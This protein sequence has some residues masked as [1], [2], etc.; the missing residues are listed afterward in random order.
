[1]LGAIPPGIKSGRPRKWSARIMMVRSSAVSTWR[2]SSMAMPGT[3]VGIT[4]SEPPSRGENS[5]LR[6]K[7]KGHGVEHHCQRGGD[8][9]EAPAYDE[10]GDGSVDAAEEA[11][12]GVFVL[13]SKMLVL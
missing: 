13:S 9:R 10:D 3:M 12:E 5:E 2:A 1:M 8:G 6:R 11:V 7:A 4:G